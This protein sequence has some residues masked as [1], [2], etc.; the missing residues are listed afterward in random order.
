MWRLVLTMKWRN[1]LKFSTVYFGGRKNQ[2][3]PQIIDKILYQS[4][5]IANH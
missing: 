3:Y 5:F 2:T 1:F 4:V